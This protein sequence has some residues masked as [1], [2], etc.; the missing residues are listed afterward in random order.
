MDINFVKVETCGKD[1]ILYKR[2]LEYFLNNSQYKRLAKHILNRRLAVGGEGLVILFKTDSLNAQLY[3]RYT[4]EDYPPPEALCCIGRYAFDS[5]LILKRSDCIVINNNTYSIKRIDSKNIA[6][7]IGKPRLSNGKQEL[8]EN[9]HISLGISITLWEKFHQFVPVYIYGLHLIHF[10]TDFGSINE[11]NLKKIYLNS[12]LENVI[13]VTLVKIYSRDEI[14]IKTWQPE[15]NK[16][17]ILGLAGA[18]SVVASIIQ[19][20]TDREV[21][22]R[23]KDGEQFVQWNIQTNE[24]VVTT[25][26]NYTFKGIYYYNT[27]N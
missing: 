13:S 19:G 15:K 25:H 5:G 7:N 24:I 22:V 11:S 2:D 16:K 26:V 10:T 9:P 17:V 20:L 18:A 12:N 27:Q 1:Y 23:S 8:V 14:R 21:I 6:V 3:T 4:L